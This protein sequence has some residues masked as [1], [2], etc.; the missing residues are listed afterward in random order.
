M[1][2]LFAMFL[3][4]NILMRVVKII[5]YQVN[6]QTLEMNYLFFVFL[7]LCRGSL[8]SEI[9]NQGINVCTNV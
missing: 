9:Q 7:V 2:L 5:Q 1:K 4:E 8:Q 6:V 3:S